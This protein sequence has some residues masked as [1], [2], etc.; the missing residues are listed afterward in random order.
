MTLAHDLAVLSQGDPRVIRALLRV[1]DQP[2]GAEAVRGL[3]ENPDAP[4]GAAILELHGPELVTGG[5]L[6]RLVLARYA[7]QS[8]QPR[9]TDSEHA[10][11]ACDAGLQKLRS[12]QGH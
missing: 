10:T 4:R 9:T 5:P 11:V 3:L 7:R 8:I 2:G 12:T 1:L 6:A